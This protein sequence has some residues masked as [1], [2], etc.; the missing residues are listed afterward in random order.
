MFASI[1]AAVIASTIKHVD[2][3]KHTD[4]DPHQFTTSPHHES[5][6][7]SR[8]NLFVCK[9]PNLSQQCSEPDSHF[10]HEFTANSAAFEIPMISGVHNFANYS[11]CSTSSDDSDSSEGTFVS[12]SSLSSPASQESNP[13]DIPPV[14]SSKSG[15]LKLTHNG[16]TYTIH[17]VLGS[18][19]YGQVVCAT[20]DSGE[21]V[22]IKV[23]TKQ[24][25]SK[26]TFAASSCYR[27][28]MNERNILVRIANKSTHS[29]FLTSPLACFQDTENVYFVMRMFTHTLKQAIYS[30]GLQTQQM[31]VFAVELLLGIEALHRAGIV[32][33][34]LK[35]DNVLISPNG[36]L[37]VADF[38][39]AHAFAGPVLPTMRMYDSCGTLGY[40]APEVISDKIK[41]HGYSSSA[42]VWGYGMILYEMLIGRRAVEAE[43]NEIREMLNITLQTKIHGDIDR[44]IL[45]VDPLAADLLHQLLSVQGAKR[46]S[47]T[48][49]RRHAWFA[50]VNWAAVEARTCDGGAT[51]PQVVLRDLRPYEPRMAGQW[52]K[53]LVRDCLVDYECEAAHKQDTLH[54]TVS[55]V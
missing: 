42:D 46:P 26:S 3:D 19:G 4:S 50:D 40:M 29:A 33:R 48:S 37:A 9:L 53:F 18:G 1:K 30:H 23:C 38:G 41:T 13:I 11:T 28:V 32:H 47:W 7:T 43:T 22:A 52:R 44:K 5:K 15:P 45:E 6:E 12:S 51:I 25:H 14:D 34:D 49:I 54:G 36:H 21:Q 2:C 55:L 8:G 35:P 17:G 31:K 24:V 20:T 16:T 10:E 27:S 39:L